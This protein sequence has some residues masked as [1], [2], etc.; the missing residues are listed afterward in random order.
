MVSRQIGLLMR[1][2]LD[3]SL[4]ARWF[5]V[6]SATFLAG[7]LLLATFGL[8]NTMV[9]GYRG[10][11]K[12]FAGLVHLALLFV[13]L[14]A[15]FPAAAAIAEERESGVL[16]FLLAQPTSSSEVFFGK[17]GGLVLA[18]FLSLTIGFGGA[19]AVAAVQG[20]PPSLLLALYGFVLLLA[21]CFVSLGLCFSAV[22]ATRARALTLGFISWLLLVA[23]GTLGIIVA[24]VRW[25]LPEQVLSLW[26]VVNPVEAFRVAVIS[27]LDADLS[28]LGPVG[29]EVVARF[30]R[31]GTIALMVVSLA[32]WS[33]APGCFG[34]W[35]F[36]RKV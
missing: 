18:L 34:L 6:Y 31:S 22:A 2:E 12:A 23:L 1:R 9:Y 8:Q 35:L 32:I 4:R 13:P 3:A 21:L 20:V 29:G 10:F 15:L 16:E 17:W 19:G 5:Y 28:L 14:M 7:G 33:L 30:G 24:F 27:V 25:G 26:T 11:A 36:R